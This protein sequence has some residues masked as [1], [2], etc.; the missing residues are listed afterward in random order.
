[1]FGGPGSE[2]PCAVC[3]K[4]LPRA[5]VEI[6]LEYNRCGATP[7]IDKFHFHQSCYAAFERSRVELREPA[8]DA[9]EHATRVWYRV[10][11][12]LRRKELA[13]ETFEAEIRSA[14]HQVW[15]EVEQLVNRMLTD[16]QFGVGQLMKTLRERAEQTIRPTDRAR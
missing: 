9:H 5:Q 1:M 14:Q 11:G 13:I 4:T 8:M 12:L 6:E 16:K 10:A 15:L 3:G 2:Q 7:G